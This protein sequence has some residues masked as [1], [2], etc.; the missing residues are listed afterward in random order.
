M[1]HP[2]IVSYNSA[3]PKEHTFV[4]ALMNYLG[5]MNIYAI[6]DDPNVSE[7][8]MKQ[9]L[10]SAQWLVL[11]LTPEAISSPHVQSLVNTA[12]ARVGQGYMQ[13]V[14]ALTFSSNPVELED[15]PP[16]WS[17]IRIYYVGESNEDYQQAFEKLSR[18]LSSMR[19]PVPATSS[20]TNNWASS[21]SSVD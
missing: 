3:N 7:P 9:R 13:G 6:S 10:L 5:A 19:V 20:S 4:K 14:L 11:L 2:I 15:M 12:F 1:S 18:T 17:T 16:L 21:F 8:R